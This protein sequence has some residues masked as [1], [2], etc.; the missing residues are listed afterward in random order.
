MERLVEF[1]R[2]LSD[3]FD[4]SVPA[5]LALNTRSHSGILAILGCDPTPHSAIQD[6]RATHGVAPIKIFC[7][8]A[9]SLDC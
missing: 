3:R 5:A 8:D 7:F 4:L 6:K 9:V 2:S 1:S